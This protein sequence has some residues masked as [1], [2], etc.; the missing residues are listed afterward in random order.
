VV[1]SILAAPDLVD[2]L[3]EVVFKET[4]TLGVRISEIKKRKILERDVQTVK[5]P[6]GEA[7]VK[8]RKASL[9]QIT[10]APEYDDCKYLAQKNNLPIQTVYD[11]V[12]KEAEKKMSSQ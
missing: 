7:R 12:K 2:A 1:L 5:T 10:F 3:C 11:T 4:T 6:W 9:D 8:I